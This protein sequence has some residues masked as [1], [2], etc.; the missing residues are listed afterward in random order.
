MEVVPIRASRAP[1]ATGPRTAN[2]AGLN[3]GQQAALNFVA[4]MMLG[5][6]TQSHSQSPSPPPL[7]HTH[8]HTSLAVHADAAED[9]LESGAAQAAGEG[10][11]VSHDEVRGDSCGQ[12]V[13]DGHATARMLACA[14]LFC[15]WCGGRGASGAVLAC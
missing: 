14:L 15:Q 1:R 2:R 8:T 7:P 10:A 12:W 13:N 9:A 5:M 6:R 11:P 4:W 3:N